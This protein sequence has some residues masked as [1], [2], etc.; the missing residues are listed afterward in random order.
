M[1]S[2]SSSCVATLGNGACRGGLRVRAVMP[3]TPAA[4]RV[5]A[6]I[7][8]SPATLRAEMPDA[9]AGFRGRVVTADPLERLRNRA[10]AVRD[11]MP[12]QCAEDWTS[13]A[14][15]SLVRSKALDAEA[16]LLEAADLALPL[17]RTTKCS[18]DPS[19]MP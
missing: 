7:P 4:L 9:P 19:V 3:E 16:V 12:E 17:C 5:R 13:A 15:P 1:S 11:V 14:A 18:T 6:V 8:D 2:R 10:G